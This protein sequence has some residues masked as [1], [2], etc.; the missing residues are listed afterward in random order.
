MG[1]LCKEFFLLLID[2]ALAGDQV[3]LVRRD[4]LG[5]EAIFVA[6]EENVEGGDGDIGGDERIYLEGYEG[7][8]TFEEGDDSGGDEGKV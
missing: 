1:L 7:V 5:L 4:E 6:G 3:D 2:L 8:V